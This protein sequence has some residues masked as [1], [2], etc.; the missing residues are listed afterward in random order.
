MTAL[1]FISDLHYGLDAGGDAA[2]E[3]LA[4][5]LLRTA[6]PEDV[7][8]VLGDIGSDPDTFRACLDLFDGFPGSKCGVAGNHDIWVPEGG[9]SCERLI[10][11]SEDFAASG[12]HA[13]EQTPLLLG[14]IAVVGTIGWYDG[15]FRD[16]IGVDAEDYERKYCP[17][18]NAG[19]ADAEHVRWDHSDAS[20]TEHTAG[21]LAA[22]LATI[23]ASTT[24]ICCTHHLPTRRLLHR[25]RCLVPKHWRFTNAF[26]GSD[27]YGALLL[28]DAR[29]QLA[30]S[31]HIHARRTHRSG[32]LVF[33][34]VGGDYRDKEVVAWDG[35]SLQ[36]LTFK[37]PKHQA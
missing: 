13:L 37:A 17:S 31:G 15:S 18:L 10:E 11:T 23:P 3:R 6:Q 14:P 30:V 27:C 28:G 32:N 5:H 26:L 2:T 9:N 8:C 29:V 25:P 1:F 34:T 35:G 20:F 24:I 22:H 19:W 7:L 12:F 21:K 4:A 36:R 33:A 16:D